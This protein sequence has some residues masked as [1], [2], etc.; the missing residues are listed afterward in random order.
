[1]RVSY[2]QCE[3]VRSLYCPSH[4]LRFDGLHWCLQPAV[5]PD[6][7][8]RCGWQW[9]HPLTPVT[10]VM[11]GVSPLPPFT[12]GYGRAFDGYTARVLSLQAVCSC[13]V[14]ISC[15]F[16]RRYC[17]FK[18]CVTQ[19]YS[20]WAKFSYSRVTTNKQKIG[21]NIIFASLS[22]KYYSCSRDGFFKYPWFE[23]GHGIIEM[24][25]AVCTIFWQLP[26]PL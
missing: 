19:R 14:L 3:K 1:M 7:V 12:A 24:P 8:G 13:A 9:H 22:T 4:I 20:L 6:G 15:C 11:K 16:R 2:G 25:C 18:L 17:C 5:T 10:Q 26:Q 21:R 23:E